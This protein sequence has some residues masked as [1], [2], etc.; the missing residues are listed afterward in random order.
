MRALF[1]VNPN[2][3]TAGAS[4]PTVLA[5]TLGAETD[6]T[7]V[8]TERRDHA[9]EIAERAADDGVDLVIAHG[10]DGTVNEIVNGL[11][12]VPAERRPMLAVVPG[13][14]GNVFSRA[15]GQSTDP[16]EVTDRLAEA[17]RDGV[18]RR[19]SLGDVGG[20]FFTFAAGFG[21]D[22]RVVRQVDLG[23]KAGRSATTPQYVAASL[24]EYMRSTPWRRA[25]LTLITPS[26]MMTP[27]LHLLIVANTTPWTYLG[28]QP[29]HAC[30]DA[31]FDTGLDILGLR[32]FGPATL[33]QT[34]AQVLTAASP[35]HRHLLRLHD[36]DGVSIHS[37]LPISVQLDGEYA[38]EVTTANVRAHRE[39]LTVVPGIG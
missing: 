16:A 10:G 18:R 35:R 31:S 17:I 6:L 5:A 28:D 37:H 23:R 19:I 26:G 27:G 34:F 11:M 3:T 21:F 22:A 30:P 36:L 12:R 2:A 13:G 20:R 33:A 24:R 29:L 32:R 8:P 7:I 39:A 25:P 38:G 14:H 4:N 15:L 1:V 9:T